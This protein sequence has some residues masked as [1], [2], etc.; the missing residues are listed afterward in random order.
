[1][2][3]KIYLLVLAM[4]VISSL[5]LLLF[6][7]TQDFKE[8]LE[9]FESIDYDTIEIET[10]S[11]NV[12]IDEGPSNYLKLARAELGTLTLENNGY[13]EQKYTTPLLV[14]CINFKEDP[15]SLKFD[16]ETGPKYSSG[17]IKE[18]S[19]SSSNN[20]Q[21]TIK[22]GDKIENKIVGVYRDNYRDKKSISSF[23]KENIESIIVYEIPRKEM[24]PLSKN[25][26]SNY[27]YYSCEQ[28][29]L[30]LTSIASITIS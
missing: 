19:I 26:Y 30:E 17:S 7:Y 12:N 21:I 22:V 15:E 16:I 2:K 9:F 4:V 25:Y 13:F 14:G 10:A 6:Y 29:E 8:E 24:N 1:M 20:N 3:H 23:N 11:G 5:V 18:Y 28:I 27:N